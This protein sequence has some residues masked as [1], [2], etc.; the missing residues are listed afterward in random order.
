MYGLLFIQ[1][2]S[3][4]MRIVFKNSLVSNE[5]VFILKNFYVIKKMYFNKEKKYS[6]LSTIKIRNH[7]PM[8]ICLDKLLKF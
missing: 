6:I 2:L 1:S 7:S 3:K 8:Q 5:N 4:I